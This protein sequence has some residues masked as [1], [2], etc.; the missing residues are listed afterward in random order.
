MGILQKI[1]GFLPVSKR[2]LGEVMEMLMD[3]CDA[4]ESADKQHSNVERSLIKQLSQSED[5]VKAK[6][7]KTPHV[8]FG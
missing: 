5:E 1:K 4:I 2:E 7:D 3:I 8:E 6:E